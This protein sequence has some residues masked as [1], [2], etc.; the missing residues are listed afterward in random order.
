MARKQTEKSSD[1]KAGRPE[2]S[3]T[4][5]IEP[6]RVIRATCRNPECGSSDL[7]RHRVINDVEYY[8]EATDDTPETTRRRWTRAMCR[9]CSTWQTIIED[10]NP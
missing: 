3:T 4:S 7:H 8:Q 5:T 10:Y 9:K 6:V 2:G 1:K